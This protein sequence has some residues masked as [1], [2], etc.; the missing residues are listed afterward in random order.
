MFSLIPWKSRQQEPGTSISLNDPFENRLAQFRDEFNSLVDRF[1]SGGWGDP[2]GAPRW[3]LELDEDEKEYVV[4][5]EAPGFEADD[6]DVQVQGNNLFV[7]AEH[8][9]EQHNGEKGS[10]YHYGKYQRS[11]PLPPGAE[12][13]N[14]SARYHSGILELHVPKGKEAQ[15]RR[16]TVEAK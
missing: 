11:L 3:G 4:R 8:R 14:I 6:F 15:G 16:I 1:W 13:D 2:F 10:L 12:T 9:D 7:S 5:A